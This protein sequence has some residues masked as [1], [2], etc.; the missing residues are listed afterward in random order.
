MHELSKHG[1]VIIPSTQYL[2]ASWSDD[3]RV[4]V[5]SSVSVTA[6]DLVKK[7]FAKILDNPSLRTGYWT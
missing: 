7:R 2:F 3:K 4:L 6:M 5:L 1:L